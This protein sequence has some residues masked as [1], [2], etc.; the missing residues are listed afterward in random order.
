MEFALHPA[1]TVSTNSP[2]KCKVKRDIPC[3][4]CGEESA[5]ATS[6]L[7]L[8]PIAPISAIPT[9]PT[10]N[11]LLVPSQHAPQKITYHCHPNMPHTH[12]SITNAIQQLT[13]ALGKTIKISN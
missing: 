1:E 11:H 12:S 2:F 5:T 7:R 3:G 4:I 6:F 13:V 9:C 8:F 10:L